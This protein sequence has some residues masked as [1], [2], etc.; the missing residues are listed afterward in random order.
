MLCGLDEAGRGP[1]AG[2]LY[3]AAVV[4]PE[5]FPQDGLGGA[6]GQGLSLLRDSKA[7]PPRQRARAA[8]WI[9]RHALR[10]HVLSVS[11]EEINERGIGW[12]NREVFRRLIEQVEA[13]LYVVDG[14]VLPPVS[15][16]RRRSVTCM[17]RA[18]ATVP[19]VMAASI[20]AKVARDECMASL[21]RRYPV[22]GWRC[23]MGYPT[24]G[25]LDAIVRY[26]LTPYH[27]IAFALTALATWARR[28]LGEEGAW[29]GVV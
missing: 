13:D 28:R 26:G 8:E 22:Y 12:A 11:V 25:H 20:L 10:F 4:L 27:R 23:N 19:A 18:D 21:D 9:R 24:S 3:A 1:L 5:E 2:P 16:K 29:N 17:V 15:E 6:G 14:R 7:L